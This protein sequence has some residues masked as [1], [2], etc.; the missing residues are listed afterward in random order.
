[1]ISKIE[2][3]NTL[4]LSCV[5]NYFLAWLNEY[6]DVS[7][8]YGQSYIPIERIFDDFSHGATYENYC[9]I[10]R[11]QDIA[12]EVGIVSHCY[13]PTNVVKALEI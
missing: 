13:Y 2:I 6:Y 8:L 3:T 4:S 9:S 11:L 10:P 7:N 12:E 1:M 5:E